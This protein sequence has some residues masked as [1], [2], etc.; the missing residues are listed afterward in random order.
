MEEFRDWIDERVI[1]RC[2][3]IYRETKL[4]ASLIILTLERTRETDQSPKSKFCSFD[5]KSIA[6]CRMAPQR[7]KQKQP[8]RKTR[9]KD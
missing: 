4:H 7:D 6:F 1:L 8:G 3:S 5:L 2:W 9:N